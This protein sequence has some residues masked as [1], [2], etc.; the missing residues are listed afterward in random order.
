MA[1]GLGIPVL[2]YARAQPAE[3]AH[4][5]P[6]FCALV[7]TWGCWPGMLVPRRQP[8]QTGKESI[9]FAALLPSLG[10]TYHVFL[11]C[12]QCHV[13]LSSKRPLT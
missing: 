1:R 6:L 5:W 4:L 9:S 8:P 11:I 2:G 12:K 7:M 13:P 10:T 3:T